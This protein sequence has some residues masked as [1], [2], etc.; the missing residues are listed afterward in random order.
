MERLIIAALAVSLSTPVLA[1][2]KYP[3]PSPSNSKDYGQEELKEKVLVVNEVFELSLDGTHLYRVRQTGMGSGSGSIIQFGAR[4]GRKKSVIYAN[5]F[6]DEKKGFGIKIAIYRKSG[7]MGTGKGVGLIE[8]KV[9]YFTDFSP[10][11]VE[12]ARTKKRKTVI[13]FTP[14]IGYEPDEAEQY[15]GKVLHIDGVLIKN[16]KQVVARVGGATGEKITVSSPDLGTLQV[17]LAKFKGAQPIGKLLGKTLSFELGEDKY[18]WMLDAPI[19]PSGPWIVWLKYDPKP[20][21]PKG[22]SVQAGGL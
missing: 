4:S 12:A 13:R 7:P 21:F 17:A 14:F 11:T 5:H 6:H 3:W 8:E 10:V 19:L 16:R 1:G 15:E 20:R 22:Q 18:E 2:S 9:H